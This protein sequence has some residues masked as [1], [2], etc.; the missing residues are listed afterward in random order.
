MFHLWSL[1]GAVS[2]RG[3]E[4]ATLS[5]GRSYFCRY[6]VHDER[7]NDGGKPVENPTLKLLRHFSG[8]EGVQ[9]GCFAVVRTL[10]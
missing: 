8:G 3:I 5:E 7:L 10:S 2:K 9:L 1:S 6:D 4:H